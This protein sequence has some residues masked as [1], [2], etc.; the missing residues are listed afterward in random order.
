MVTI[1]AI[2]NKVVFR[3]KYGEIL[4]ET[5]SVGITA[6]MMCGRFKNEDVLFY[7]SKGK[8]QK[9]AEMA[10]EIYKEAVDFNGELKLEILND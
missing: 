3:S 5:D 8:T 10:L 7:E 9:K 6:A 1:K 4:P 2:Q